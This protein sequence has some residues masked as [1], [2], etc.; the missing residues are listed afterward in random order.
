MTTFNSETL[1]DGTNEV[2][3]ADPVVAE[4]ENTT[5]PMAYGGLGYN[6]HY[7][8]YTKQRALELA[9]SFGEHR[10]VGHDAGDVVNNAKRF[11]AY[12]RGE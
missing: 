10:G 7:T 12:L 4:A 3:C 1:Y 11:E 6:I 8:D 2:L 9:I 5:L